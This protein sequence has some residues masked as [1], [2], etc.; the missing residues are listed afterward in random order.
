MGDIDFA[1][2]EKLKIDGNAVAA[3]KVSLPLFQY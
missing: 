1:T 2:L 3:F